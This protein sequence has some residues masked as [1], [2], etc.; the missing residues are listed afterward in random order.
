MS[1]RNPVHAPPS[2]VRSRHALTLVPHFVFFVVGAALVRLIDLNSPRCWYIVTVSAL[3]AVAYAVGPAA[4]NRLGPLARH[5]W[6]AAML[7]L[8]TVLVA[9][10]PTPLNGTYV[11]CAVPL[12]LAALRALGPR[13]VGTAGAAITVV[14]V[15]QLTRTA[16]HFD[17]ETVLIPVAAVWGTVAL[18]RAQQRDATERQLLVEELRGTREVLAEQQRRAG[19]VEERARIARDLHDTLAQE[20]AASLM[21]LQAAE[22]D[23]EKRPDVA[24]TRVRAVADGLDAGLAET[25]RI[26]RDLTPSAVAEAGLEGSLRLLCARA[27]ADGAAARVQFRSLGNQHPALDQQAAATL[28]RVAQSLLANVREHAHAMNLL[29]TLRHH[30]D[31]VE[32]EVCDDGVGLAPAGTVTVSRP[33]RG[34]GLPSVRARLRECGGDLDVGGAPGG[35]TRVRAALP[36]RPQADPARPVPS[37]TAR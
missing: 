36:A 23:W 18:Y 37:A 15:G 6:I 21:L 24:H 14:L 11:W 35:G 29:V 19:V 28:F 32:L 16:G 4:W 1:D 31:R 7:L 34:F 25:R 13:S 3:L 30:P 5:I 2:A 8:W 20:L 12:A 26:I 27:Q 9:I 10:V 33:G 22:R 17:P